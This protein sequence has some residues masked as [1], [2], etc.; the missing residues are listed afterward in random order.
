MRE[1]TAAQ[2]PIHP[3]ET[4]PCP[5][6]NE[7]TRAGRTVNRSKL[8]LSAFGDIL[9]HN[10][11]MDATSLMKLWRRMQDAAQAEQTSGG[12]DG[13][14]AIFGEC[15]RPERQPPITNPTAGIK[16]G[17]LD[18]IADLCARLRD[19]YEGCPSPV[20][21]A[22]VATLREA[23][24]A[25]ERLRAERAEAERDTL[26][27]CLKSVVSA[28]DDDYKPTWYERWQPAVDAARAKVNTTEGEK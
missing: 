16:P 17:P 25:L 1:T 8:P 7:G 19:E 12:V 23:A 10:Y 15:V 14:A 4:Q 21:T 13:H 6:C 3:L 5:T 2:C 20:T 9:G 11:W 28:W 18:P 26:R 22:R 27:K 24:D